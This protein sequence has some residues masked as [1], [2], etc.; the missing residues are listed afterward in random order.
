[1]FSVILKF[2]LEN[3]YAFV[4]LLGT[5]IVWLFIR[6]N[7]KGLVMHISF[8]IYMLPIFLCFYLDPSDQA[9]FI[10]SITVSVGLATLLY[11][12]QNIESKETQQKLE[13]MLKG[14]LKIPEAVQD[15]DKIR[16]I[17]YNLKNQNKQKNG[18]INRD[19]IENAIR[20]LDEV[21][22]KNK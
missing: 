8:F 1:M 22:K 5:F 20:I 9:P 7:F 4:V 19:E 12:Q 21:I 3:L 11:C 13:N 2:I 10:M 6:K 16:A 17:L 18:K 15:L 14:K